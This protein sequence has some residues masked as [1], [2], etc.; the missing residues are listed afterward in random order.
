[1]VSAIFGIIAF[2]DTPLV[3]YSIRLWTD[4]HHPPAMLETGKIDPGMRPALLVCWAVFQLLLIYL[5]RRRFF[6]ESIRVDVEGLER[7]AG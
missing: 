2:L 7:Q 6:L 4:I 5:L 3:W 1:M